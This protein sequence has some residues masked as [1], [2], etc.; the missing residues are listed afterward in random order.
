MKKLI[1]VFFLFS[2]C[3]SNDKLEKLKELVF[4]P[5]DFEFIDS[6]KTKDFLTDGFTDEIYVFKIK[7][8]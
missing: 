5:T 3:K 8:K 1:I 2:F 7:K 6:R 4:I